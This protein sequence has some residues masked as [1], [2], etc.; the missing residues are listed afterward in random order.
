[1]SKP[2]EASA[3]GVTN[4][5]HLEKLRVVDDN[6]PSEKLLGPEKPTLQRCRHAGGQV[7]ESYNASLR[8]GAQRQQRWAGVARQKHM[9]EQILNL[10]AWKFH[11]RDK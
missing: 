4:V 11:L 9:F 7:F 8:V 3:A 2:Q 5:P 1:M 6:M 10:V